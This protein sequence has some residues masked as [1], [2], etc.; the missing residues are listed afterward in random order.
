[1]T[2]PEWHTPKGQ[3]RREQLLHAAMTVIG[4][5][6]YAGATQRAIATEAGVPPASTHYFFD[7]VDELA[8]AAAT[9]YLEERLALYEDRIAAFA[10]SDLSPADGCREVAALLHT[11]SDEA[12]TAQFEIYLN[13]QRQSELQDTVLDAITRL[14]ALCARLLAAMDVPQPEVWAKAFLAVG[15]GFALHAV[16]GAPGD[17]DALEQALLAVVLAGRA[18]GEAAAPARRS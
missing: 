2:R 9:Q 1:M 3:R 10:S 15:D 4:Q 8:R 16:A 18:A 11:V 14:E 7:S 13:A 12:R 5:R 6:G 17:V